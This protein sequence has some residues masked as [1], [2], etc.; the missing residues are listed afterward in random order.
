[1]AKYLISTSETYRVDNEK[2]AEQLILEA[3]ENNQYTLIKYN[4]IHKERKV[5]GAVEEEWQKVTLTK[6]FNEEKEPAVFVDI[7]YEVGE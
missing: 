4:C 5:K 3:K 7:N 2:E 1:M 6:A